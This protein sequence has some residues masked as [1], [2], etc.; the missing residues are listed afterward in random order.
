M[1]NVRLVRTRVN[2][3]LT[4]YESI[5]DDPNGTHLL[6]P[7]EHVSV[8]QIGPLPNK[9]TEV[10]IAKIPGKQCPDCGGSGDV[11]D[12]TLQTRITVGDVPCPACNGL[13]WRLN[14]ELH[15]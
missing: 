8:A 2:F 3:Y 1:S 10:L 6:V 14:D 9:G 5:E 12:G 11:S 13:G 7:V 4:Q 15:H